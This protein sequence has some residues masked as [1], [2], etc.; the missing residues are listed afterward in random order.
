MGGDASLTGLVAHARRGD[1]GAGE[2]LFLLVYGELHRLAEQH[3][4]HQPPGH[5]LQATAL[6][7]EAYLRVFRGE[8]NDREHFMAV[9]ARALRSVLVDHARARARDK[10]SP[11]GVRVPLE[12]LVAELEQRSSGLLALDEALERLGRLDERMV[13]LVELRF[14]AGFSMSAAARALGLPL[15]TAQREWSTARAWLRKELA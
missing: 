12:E 6:V 8:W 9:A 14:F 11:A 15:R 10:R 3:M 13:R 2:D 7:N 5:T 4:R 1:S